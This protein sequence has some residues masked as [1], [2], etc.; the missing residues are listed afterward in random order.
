MVNEIITDWSVPGGGSGLSI[1][2]ADDANDLAVVRANIGT[3]WGE[4]APFISLDSSWVVRTEGR[5]LNTA[6]GAL[7]G[8]WSETTA[9]NGSG[10]AGSGEVANATQVLFRW[11]TST[12][13]NG[14]LVQGRTYVPG[15][16]S[17]N[18]AVGQLDP[19]VVTDLSAAANSFAQSPVGIGIW[20]RP[21]AG[22]GG[23]ISAITA[24]SVWAELAV[25]RKRRT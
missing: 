16:R 14:R 8:G 2:Y 17:V 12:I 25:M 1:M 9:Q 11:R 19:G 13:V 15:L 6:S 10:T 20:H 22:T 7:T 24:G 5:T 3:L 4:L 21:S 18:L 23:S